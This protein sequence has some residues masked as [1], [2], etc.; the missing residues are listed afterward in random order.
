M[1]MSRCE[2]KS[3]SQDNLALHAQ[4]AQHRTT[5]LCC[6]KQKIRAASRTHLHSAPTRILQSQRKRLQLPFSTIRQ[7]TVA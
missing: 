5:S 7:P 1:P 2:V 3:C 4:T 6:V